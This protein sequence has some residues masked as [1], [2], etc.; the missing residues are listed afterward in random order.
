M[1]LLLLPIGLGATAPPYI[2]TI[3]LATAIQALWYHFGKCWSEW[4]IIWQYREKDENFFCLCIVDLGIII[5]FSDK[6]NRTS[7]AQF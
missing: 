6:I 2:S 3:F 1:T 7:N 4:G 5:R